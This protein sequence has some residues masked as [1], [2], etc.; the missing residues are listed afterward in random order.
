MYKNKI[1]HVDIAIIIKLSSAPEK[2]FN[3]EFKKEF[4]KLD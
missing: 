2:F 4:K 3:F 1:D